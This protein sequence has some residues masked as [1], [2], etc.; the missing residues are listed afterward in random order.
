[1]RRRFALLI[2]LAAGFSAGAQSP[3]NNFRFAILGDRTGGAVPEVYEQAWR[4]I[5][6]LRPD[7]V[8]NVG[9]TIQGRDDE[10]AEAEWKQMRA[11]FNRYRMYPL[12]F[13]AG[14]HDIWSPF[15][16]QVFERETKRPATYSFSYQNARFIVLDNS[17]TAD[18]DLTQLQFLEADL[19]ANRE[20]DPKFVFFHQPFWIT[21]LKFQSGAFPLHRLAR[22]Y[23]VRYVV[24]GHTHFLLQMEREGVAYLQMGSSGARIQPDFDKGAFYQFGWVEVRGGDVQVTVK[25]L[26]PPLGQG[27]S[28]RL[29]R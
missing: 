24:S 28:V 23:G 9:D 18:L 16:R 1:M 10:T 22:E 17:Q 15:S 25:E 7:F 8:I 13:V 27:R 26:G 12:Y 19:K 29:S 2:L 6:R 4:E 3:A 5:G 20:R 21:F 14:N 11:L